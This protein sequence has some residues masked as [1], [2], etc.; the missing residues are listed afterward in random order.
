M[1]LSRSHKVCLYK[2]RNVCLY[3]CHVLYL[4]Y[5]LK[6]VRARDCHKA[7]TSSSS[8]K[9]SDTTSAQCVPV[10]TKCLYNCSIISLYRTAENCAFAAVTLY[11]YTNVA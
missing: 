6:F 1:Y 11:L 8:T 2:S 10:V 3:S 5:C 7:Y 4:R 9:C